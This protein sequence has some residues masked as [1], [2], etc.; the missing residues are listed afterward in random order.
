MRTKEHH[1]FSASLVLSQPSLPLAICF[2]IFLTL[3]TTPR[4]VHI[5]WA[6]SRCTCPIPK[7]SLTLLAL[8]FGLLIYSMPIELPAIPVRV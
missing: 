6:G 1:L 3:I 4:P 7:V 2:T 8:L 5:R